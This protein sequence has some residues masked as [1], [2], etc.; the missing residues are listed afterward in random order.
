MIA[1]TG[2]RVHNDMT[3]DAAGSAQARS[4]TIITNESPSGDRRLLLAHHRGS[5]FQKSS[6]VCKGNNEIILI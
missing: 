4:A 1:K 5:D 6:T 2:K 3:G